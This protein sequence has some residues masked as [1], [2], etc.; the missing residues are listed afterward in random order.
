MKKIIPI[1]LIL[2]SH[3]AF[4]AAAPI[5]IQE[6][7][8]SQRMQ[9]NQPFERPEHKVSKSQPQIQHSDKAISL[10]KQELL[11]QPHLLNSAMLST[12]IT[13]NAEDVLFLLPIYQKLSIAEQSREIMQWAKAVEARAKQNYAQSIKL[14]R[15]LL[16]NYPENQPI[17]MQ[18]A[19]TLFEN[20]ENEAAEAQFHKL[21]ADK[22]P[23]E[24]ANIIHH[25]L[26]AINKQD[27]WIFQG[28]LTFLND[29]NINNAPASGTTHNGW[30]ASRKES[31]QGVGLNVN[32]EKKWSWG[33]GIFHEFHLNG[34][35]K[36]YWNNKKYNEYSLRESF[37][38][39]YQNAK[40]KITVLPFLEQM[41]YAGG[42]TQSESTK[43]YSNARGVNTRWQYWITPQWQS[44][45]TYEY[46]EQRY[47]R[48]KHLDGNYHFISPSVY[49]YP[50]SQQY[51]FVGANFNRNST[52]DL[53]DSFIRK[54]ISLGWG[55]EWKNGLSSQLSVSYA[56]KQHRAPMPIFL[57]TQRN[58]E[59]GV[60][61]SLWH[62]ALH[63]KGITPRLTWQYNKVKSNHAFYNYD[64]NRVYIEFSH[65]F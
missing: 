22:L 58:K 7:I 15:E 35:G 5:Q 42:S 47:T 63:F 11:K 48:R 51:W 31:A 12:L 52:R 23:P 8:D 38:L 40:Q 34:N 3:F 6:K 27:R 57:I 30:T 45:I 16:A 62:R 2:T 29:P 53:D 14:Y 54:G 33:N 55:Q 43:R 21:Q 13:G 10:S 4:T 17:R 46:A 44:S 61:V 56:R 41:W 36:Y 39:G 64:K 32:V 28:G 19:V 18:L 24:I 25:Y 50:S 49:Y 60:Q 37:G 65:T 20:R 1:S 9:Q 26:A 59:Y